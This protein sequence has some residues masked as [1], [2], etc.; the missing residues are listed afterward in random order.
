MKAWSN[1]SA[2]FSRSCT[3]VVQGWGIT[4]YGE[5]EEVVQL[6][7]R[8]S[9]FRRTKGDDSFM[10]EHKC[11]AP[12]S[13]YFVTGTDDKRLNQVPQETDLI[14]TADYHQIII[15]NIPLRKVP[16]NFSSHSRD[17]SS[18]SREGH[19]GRLERTRSH[20]ST[21][22]RS[23]ASRL[24]SSTRIGSRLYESNHTSRSASAFSVSSIAKKPAPF[25]ATTLAGKPAP[26][27]AATLAK[28]PAPFR[29]TTLARKPAPF[30]A[31]Y[32]QIEPQ[33]GGNIHGYLLAFVLDKQEL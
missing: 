15:K 5:N 9:T 12:N 30:R 17:R 1:E 23:R 14:I 27:R 20:R 28:K 33:A 7:Y 16:S 29:A 21:P 26:F 22:R 24:N 19:S 31:S 18:F 10:Y 32:R 8:Q 4:K 25:S 3:Y 6:E 11:P 2:Q 13:N